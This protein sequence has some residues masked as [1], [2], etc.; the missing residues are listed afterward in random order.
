MR[1]LIASLLLLSTS[2]GAQAPAAPAEPPKPSESAG[3]P[4]APKSE[5][6]PGT[7]EEG[8]FTPSEEV[9]ADKEVDFPAD[10]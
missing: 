3:K 5:P 10:L 2:A 4:A 6:R 8:V 9:S 7:P 1:I